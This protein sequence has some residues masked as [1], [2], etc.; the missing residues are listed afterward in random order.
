MRLLL[1]ICLS[2][3][4]QCRGEILRVM[5]DYSEKMVTK[6]LVELTNFKD[7]LVRNELNNLAELMVLTKVIE[8]GV[9]YWLLNKKLLP[10]SKL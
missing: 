2:S 4:S 7:T 9:D 3:V 5:L 8:N 10:L 1:D 6:D